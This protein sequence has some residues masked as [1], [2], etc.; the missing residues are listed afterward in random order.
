ML[1]LR[2]SSRNAAQRPCLVWEIHDTQKEISDLA[3]SVGALVICDAAQSCGMVPSKVYDLGV[4]VY[5]CSGQKWLLGPDGTGAL[6][7]RKDQIG[8]IKLL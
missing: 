4:D 3:H 7:V 2:R 5:A 6:F 8:Q 1:L